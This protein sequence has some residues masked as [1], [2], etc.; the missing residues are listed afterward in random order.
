MGVVTVDQSYLS[1]NYVLTVGVAAVAVGVAT[2]AVGVV[3][4]C[5]YTC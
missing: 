3:N 4:V 5:M 2:V 1:C